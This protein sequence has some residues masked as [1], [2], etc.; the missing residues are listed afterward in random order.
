V[1]AL[2]LQ[3][4]KTGLLRFEIHGLRQHLA[5]SFQNVLFRDP[6]IKTTY[7]IQC[8]IFRAFVTIFKT[9]ERRVSIVFVKA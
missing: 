8:E 5:I 9:G 6:R 4:Y 2:D 1:S 3:N 7:K